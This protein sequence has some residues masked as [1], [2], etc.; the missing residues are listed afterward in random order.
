MVGGQE[1]TESQSAKCSPHPPFKGFSNR[2]SSRYAGLSKFPRQAEHS[3]LFPF[4]FGIFM[5][6]LV[7]FNEGSAF[8]SR[9]A[10]LAH[11]RVHM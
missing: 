5:F 10:L 6:R 9:V 8:S 7:P 3:S 1:W 4:P 11:V 2:Q